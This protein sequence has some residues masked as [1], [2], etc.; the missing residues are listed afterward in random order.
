MS[1][2]LDL[3]LF[4]VGGVH[5]GVDAGQVA[6]IATYDGEQAG[7]LFWFHEEISYSTKTVRYLSPTV[8]TI[9]IREG[10][11]YRVIIDS[12]EDIAAFTLDDISLFPSLLEPF[13]LPRGIWGI[14]PRNGKMI[15]LL[16]F[17]IL[18]RARESR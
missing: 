6:G 9:R 17:E 12:M 8:I 7:D 5:F 10:A 18:T 2:R 16:D 11:S 4:S 13:V 14:V 1:E 15:L 3:L